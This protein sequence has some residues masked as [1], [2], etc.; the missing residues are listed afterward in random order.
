MSEQNQKAKTINE[1][2]LEVLNFWKENNIFEKSLEKPAGEAPKEGY[3]FYDG[4][5]FQLLLCHRL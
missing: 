1:K 4:P 3:T 5:P 2:E